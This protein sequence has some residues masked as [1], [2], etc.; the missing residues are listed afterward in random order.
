MVSDLTSPAPIPSSTSTKNMG[1][2]KRTNR[3]A[4]LKQCKFDARRQQWL[5]QVVAKNKGCSDDDARTPMKGSKASLE[6][7]EMRSIDEEEDEGL[8]DHGS[9][10]ELV[11]NSPTSVNNC[12]HYGTN[13][14][15]CCSNGSSSSSSASSAGCRSGNV[16][17]DEGDDG[18]LDDW[19]AM[20]DALA[21][22]DKNQNPSSEFPPEAE[23]V[24]QMV[25]PG[26]L[27][28]GL[29]AVPRNCKPDSAR[30]DSCSSRNGRAWRPNDAFRPQCLPNLSKQHS[31]PTPDRRCGGGVPWA[32]TAAP[33]PCPICCEDLDLTDAS[34]LPCLCGFSICLFCH[35]RIIEEDGRCPGCRKPYECE[36]IETEAS[37]HGGSLT[38]RLAH[39]RSMFERS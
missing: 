18:C 26:E 4:K 23:P 30:L 12:I 19:E 25:L 14:T 20:A 21:A 2:K 3:S 34:F 15:G 35:K 24:V 36:P 27:I 38:L 17:E 39:S 5:S 16:T 1:K 31:L 37:V 8:I 13:F 33:L 22:N 29:N 32:F 7:L 6:K 10:S 9:Y 28:N 11:S